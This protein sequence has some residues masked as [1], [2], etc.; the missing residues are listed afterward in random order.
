MRLFVAVAVAPGVRAG[1]TEL[2]ARLPDHALRWI[3]PQNLHLTLKFLGE[4]SEARLA[5]VVEAARDAA[6]GFAPFTIGLQGVGAFPSRR[7]AQVV[8]VG[9]REG[10][11]RLVEL[12]GALETAL[13]RR[14][15]A[16]EKRPFRP[17]LTVGRVR[18]QH[19]QVDMSDALAGMSDTEFGR[20]RVAALKIM[21][22]RLHPSGAVYG[23]IEEIPLG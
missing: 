6:E 9:V 23:V 17:H 10:A 13:A 14:R 8:W 5:R 22:S 20:Q 4:V 15:F 16:R 11:E 7:H 12:A 19:G 2:P 3:P 1:L 18:G 21:E